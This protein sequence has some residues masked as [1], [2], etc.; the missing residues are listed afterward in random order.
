MYL[1]VCVSYFFIYV[2]AYSWTLFSLG[3]AFNCIHVCAV[4]GPL[5]CFLF[6]PLTPLFEHSPTGTLEHGSLVPK[7]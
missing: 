1:C 6:W 7:D 3:V 4:A 5:G 2:V